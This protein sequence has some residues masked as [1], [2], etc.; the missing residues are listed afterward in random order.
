MYTLFTPKDK[1]LIF[2][3]VFKFK[4]DQNPDFILILWHI[5]T[6]CSIKATNTKRSPQKPILQKLNL[7]FP[8]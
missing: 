5:F 3:N 8:R 4:Y 2:I 1:H 6:Q 7:T